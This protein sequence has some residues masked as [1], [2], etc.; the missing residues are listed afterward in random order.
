MSRT[1]PGDYKEPHSTLCF[2]LLYNSHSSQHTMSYHE[3]YHDQK[4]IQIASS[5]SSVPTVKS[6]CT[7]TFPNICQ[8]PAGRLSDEELYLWGFL[9]ET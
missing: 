4:I 3:H 6:L 9:D 7:Q 8:S 5:D 2:T 1:T